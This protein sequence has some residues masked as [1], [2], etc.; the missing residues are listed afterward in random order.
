MTIP[1]ET[2]PIPLTTD[3]DGV[4]RVGGTRVTLE[5]IAAAFADG[6]T[7]EEITYQFPVLNLADVYSVIGFMLRRRAD[8]ELYIEE[9]R[10]EADRVREQHAGRHGTLDL[11]ARLLARHAT[12]R[13]C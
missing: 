9:R 1:V 10:R 12:R 6:S 13:R 8:V 7:A 3:R 2:E 4:V 11:R 5:T